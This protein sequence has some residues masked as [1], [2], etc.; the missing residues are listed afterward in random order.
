M[1]A[2][3]PAVSF[4]TFFI[5]CGVAMSITAFPVLARI[6]SEQNLMNTPVGEISM[7]AAGADDAVVWCMLILVVSLIN[8]PSQQ[9]DAL[10]VFFIVLA[11]GVFLWLCIRPIFLYLIDKSE[12]ENGADQLNIT[13]IFLT[14][15]CCAFFTQAAGVD[16]IFGAF[17]CGLIVPHER[18]FAIA[19][20]EKLEDLICIMFLPLYFGY[21]GLNVN[22]AKLDNAVAWGYVVLVIF[23]ACAGNNFYY[24]LIKSLHCR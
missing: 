11:F 21:A 10:Y 4:T 3:D 13:V 1:T 19:L 9:L 22:L 15:V 20:T 2:S 7:A 17:L 8:N 6:L 12:H 18:G 16:T 14:M 5:F 23:V 24:S